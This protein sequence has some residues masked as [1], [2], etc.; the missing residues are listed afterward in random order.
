MIIIDKLKSIKDY[1]QVHVIARKITVLGLM[2]ITWATLLAGALLSPD[3]Q[4]YTAQQ[5]ETNQIFSNGTGGINLVS[6]TFSKKNGILVLQFETSDDTS[7][8]DNGIDPQKLKWQLFGKEKDTKTKMQIIPIIDNKI[9]VVI[10]NVPE[11]FEAFAIAVT[12]KTKDI[13]DIETDIDDASSSLDSSSSSSAASKTDK[14]SEDSNV[15]EFF[16]TPRNDKLK[17]KNIKDTSREDFAIN[18]IDKEIKLQNSKKSK[19]LHSIDQLESSIRDN[20]DSL[21]DLNEKSQYLS[22][23][24]KE[25]NLDDI[26]TIETDIES[27]KNTITE[28]NQTIKEI[29]N[30]KKMLRVKRSDIEKGNFKFTDSIKTVQQK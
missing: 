22:G 2:I 21:S 1:Y 6:Q 16:I 29:N 23:E 10:K 19:L 27:K 14:E 26:K 15:V 25:D 3:R 5:L 12:N 8:V 28:A 13:Q 30:R 9:S 24:D 4:I 7:S 11:N 20:K 17:I 18:E